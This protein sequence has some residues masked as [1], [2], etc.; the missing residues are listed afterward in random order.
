MTRSS[1]WPPGP[2]AGLTGWGLLRQMARDLPATLARW[3]AEYGD[4]VHLRIWPEHQV[5]VA[6]PDLA[7]SLLIRHHDSLTR[8]EHGLRVF[9]RIHGGSVLVAEGADWQRQRRALQPLF[10]PQAVAGFQGALAAVAADHLARWQPG[11]A[12]PVEAALTDLTM[13]VILWRLASAAGEDAGH[14]AGHRSGCPHP[15]DR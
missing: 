1:P 5:V 2:P 4:V 10:S 11:P 12:R 3:Q 13:T 6:D 8:W 9:A 14:V 15:R 7:R